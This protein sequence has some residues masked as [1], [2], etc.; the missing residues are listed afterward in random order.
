MK[1]LVKDAGGIRRIGGAE[2]FTDL[3]HGGRNIRCA[4]LCRDATDNHFLFSVGLDFKT[5]LRKE[6]PI[7]G[8]KL[9]LLQREVHDGRNE[10]HLGGN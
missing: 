10:Q 9:H 2:L 1:N 6:F 4:H 5:Q 7:A 8:E 3:L